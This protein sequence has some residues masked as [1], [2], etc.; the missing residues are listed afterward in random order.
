MAKPGQSS[1]GSSS[2][3]PDDLLEGAPPQPPTMAPRSAATDISGIPRS[4]ADS[5]SQASGAL[6]V[7]G[8]QPVRQLVAKMATLE[9]IVK[10][11]SILVPA[12]S[13]AAA[14]F[15]AQMRDLGMAAL[16]DMAQGGVGGAELGTGA[17]PPMMPGSQPP[18]MMGG[19]APGGMGPGAGV[20]GMPPPPPI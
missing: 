18:P 20:P 5:M 1:T 19:G 2:Q 15:I 14:P 10:D 12:L 17:P 13:T 8:M 7:M 4:S 9:S 6:S 16:A 3:R 11:L